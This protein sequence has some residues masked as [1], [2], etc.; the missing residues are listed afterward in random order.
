MFGRMSQLGIDP[1][2]TALPHRSLGDAALRRAADL[3]ATHADFRF[4]RVRYQR[5]GVRDGV[6]QGA[7]DAEDLG[8]AVRVIHRGAWGFASGVVLTEAEAIRVAETAVE[9]AE[10]AAGMTT[11]PVEIAPEPVHD[12][13]EW[14]SAYD[15][16]PLAVPTPEKVALLVDWTNRLRAHAVS[17]TSIPFQVSIRPTDP[18]RGVSSVM[19]TAAQPVSS[20]PSTP[21]KEAATLSATRAP[22][23]WPPRTTVSKDTGSSPSTV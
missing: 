16:D 6:L 18:T 12:D 21:P 14:V 2:F 19:P 13:V 4:E 5:L 11:A 8:F 20:S 17:R 22:L 7:S 9:V 1:S 23:E 15:I 3:G 10:V